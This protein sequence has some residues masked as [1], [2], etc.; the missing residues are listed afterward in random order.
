MLSRRRF[1][2]AASAVAASAQLLAPRR[3]AASLTQPRDRIVLTVEGAIAG[4]NA[5][6]RALFDMAM[7]LGMPQAT[8]RTATPWTAGPQDFTGVLLR[9]LLAALGARGT[10]LKARALND[11]E[12]TI[13]IAEAGRYPVLLAHSRNGAPMSLRERGPL[14]IIYPLDDHAELRTPEFHSRMIWQLARLTVV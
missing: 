7:L 14:W 1:V 11:Y 6:D 10:A 5:G 13:P 12:V 8:L 9:D 3:A 2:L 4:R